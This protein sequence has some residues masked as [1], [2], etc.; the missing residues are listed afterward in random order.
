MKA[1]PFFVQRIAELCSLSDTYSS[2]AYSLN[3]KCC[4]C[5]SNVASIKSLELGMVTFVTRS[6]EA[7]DATSVSFPDV[8]QEGRE[9]A[10]DATRVV[11]V[12]PIKAFVATA[13][14]FN[15]LES[16]VGRCLG[17]R[18]LLLLD[19]S[20]VPMKPTTLTLM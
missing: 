3:G 9:K 2:I 18:P 16:K 1:F 14:C 5:R 10:E 6:E 8:R 15:S 12:S 7:F 13:T 20:L 11:D 4:C 19:A 17:S